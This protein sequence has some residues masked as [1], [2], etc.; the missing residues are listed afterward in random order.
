MTRAMPAG[1]GSNSSSSRRR[2]RRQMPGSGGGSGEAAGRER[3]Q[4]RRAGPCALPA[5]SP[6][7]L[8]CHHKVQA[9]LLGVRN[10][11]ADQVGIGA[12]GTRHAGHHVRHRIQV[13]RLGGAPDSSCGGAA[14]CISGVGCAGC[15][16]AAAHAAAAAV[17]GTASGHRGL[18]RQRHAVCAAGGQLVGAAAACSGGRLASVHGHS[19][20]LISLVDRPPALAQQLTCAM[21]AAGRRQTR[22]QT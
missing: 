16:R 21:P 9:R 19:N 10:P 12:A 5:S 18:A 20:A 14:S 2:R 17:A 22:Q 3:Q 8:T 11:V 1:C 13:E 7:C 4:Q 15:R 6:G